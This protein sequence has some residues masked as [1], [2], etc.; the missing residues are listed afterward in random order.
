MPDTLDKM[1]TKFHVWLIFSFEIIEKVYVILDRPSYIYRY[2]YVVIKFLIDK[3]EL[4]AAQVEEGL[5]VSISRNARDCRVPAE[6][7]HSNSKGYPRMVRSTDGKRVKR[8]PSQI[9]NWLECFC[10]KSHGTH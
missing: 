2:L 5:R 6:I 4:K 10:L 9:S 8:N 1:Y 7:H 3:N